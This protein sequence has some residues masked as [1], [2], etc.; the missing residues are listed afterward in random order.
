MHVSSRKVFKSISA[1]ASLANG[2]V[3]WDPKT[4]SLSVCGEKFTKCR[5]W[6]GAVREIATSR[7]ARIECECPG[8]GLCGQQDL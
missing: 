8:L 7:Q 1:E 3:T 4:S 5:A 2:H 6:R